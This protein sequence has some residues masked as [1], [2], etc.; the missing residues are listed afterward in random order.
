MKFGSSTALSDLLE[1]VI[2]NQR[3]RR[4]EEC[5]PDRQSGAITIGVQVNLQEF[6]VTLGVNSDRC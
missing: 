2:D 6:V 4:D 1:D 5:G 3:D